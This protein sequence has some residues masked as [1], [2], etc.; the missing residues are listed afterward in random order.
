MSTGVGSP[1][2]LHQTQDALDNVCA[3]GSETLNS[4]V[5]LLGSHVNSDPTLGPWKVPSGYTSVSS[6]LCAGRL[7]AKFTDK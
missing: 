7:K 4:S 2:T 5:C 3:H 6:E 1:W